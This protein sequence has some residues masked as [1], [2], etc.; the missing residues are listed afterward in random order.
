MNPMILAHSLEPA[1]LRRFVHAVR[2]VVDAMLIQAP[3]PRPAPPPGMRDYN[4]APLVNGAPDGGWIDVSELQITSQRMN[5]AI[6][7]ERWVD[8]FVAAVELLLL[9][10]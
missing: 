10:K 6:A 2:N 9:L 5:E 1:V 8:G 7:A 3:P 4:A